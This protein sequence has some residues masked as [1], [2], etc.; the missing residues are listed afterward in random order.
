MSTRRPK[1]LQ[2]TSPI[3]EPPVDP[4]VSRRFASTRGKDT[5]PELSVRRRLHQDGFRFRVHAA[6]VQGLRRSG[7]IVFPRL[8]V[9]V[10]IDGCFFH[11][12][13][14]HYV[15][16]KTRTPF[17][18][19][20]ISLNRT[21]DLETTRLFETEGWTVLRFWEHEDLDQVV[22]EIERV[23]TL[24]RSS[25]PTASGEFVQE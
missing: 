3:T 24:A 5:Q 6:P 22:G 25:Q 2:A 17:W 16:P 13:P 11:G 18:D 8:R 10:L 4:A 7:D 12:C 9:V 14:L 23:V 20:K 15:S 19:E 21:R 1:D